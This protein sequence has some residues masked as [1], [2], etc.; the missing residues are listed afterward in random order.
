VEHLRFEQRAIDKH[1]EL[2]S[3]ELRDFA[4]ANLGR[5]TGF[6]EATQH[7]HRQRWGDAAA[8]EGV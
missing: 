6:S 5:V 8:F 3:F 7:A 4:L 1:D 2:D